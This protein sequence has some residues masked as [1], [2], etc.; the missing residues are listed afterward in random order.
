MKNLKF[1]NI[2]FDNG[3]TIKSVNLNATDTVRSKKAEIIYQ[4]PEQDKTDFLFVEDNNRQIYIVPKIDCPVKVV[5][6]DDRK[7]EICI[8]IEK[9]LKNKNIKTDELR[10]YECKNCGRQFFI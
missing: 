1:N 5:F 8:E 6:E 9:E 3:S 2:E 7:C 10:L 4:I